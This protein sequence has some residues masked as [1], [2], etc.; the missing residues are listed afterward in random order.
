[1]P[2]IWCDVADCAMFE[3][4][5]L[6]SVFQM[7]RCVPDV[8]LFVQMSFIVLAFLYVIDCDVIVWHMC[9]HLRFSSIMFTLC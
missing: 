2:W 5:V 4:V 8:F 3:D 6:S 1:M 9:L 7:S